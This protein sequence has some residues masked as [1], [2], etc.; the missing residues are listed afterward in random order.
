MLFEFSRA[1]LHVDDI[2]IKSPSHC[3]LFYMIMAES[4][5]GVVAA[6]KQ[7]GTK[8]A[9]CKFTNLGVRAGHHMKI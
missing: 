8:R 2:S 9:S 6:A 3:I 5:S 4:S 1:Y 7:T